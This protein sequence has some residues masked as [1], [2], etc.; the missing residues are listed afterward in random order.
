MHTATHRWRIG[1]ILLCVSA[2]VDVSLRVYVCM[3][4]HGWCV[5][6]LE[7]VCVYESRK[8]L[9]HPYAHAQGLIYIRHEIPSIFILYILV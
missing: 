3:R 6:V 4:V 1:W 8:R 9:R 7:F 5:Y 2:L